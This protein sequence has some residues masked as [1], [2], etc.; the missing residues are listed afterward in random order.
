M[1]KFI[2]CPLLALLASL[3]AVSTRAWTLNPIYSTSQRRSI[4]LSKLAVIDKQKDMLD[5]MEE[6]MESTVGDQPSD[7]P[8]ERDELANL[9]RCI[10]RAAD[11]RKADNIVAIRISK[12][13]SLASFVVIL[14]GNSRPQNQAI[15][16]AIKSDV[17][18]DF[19]LL[20]G[21]TGV[22]EG[23]ADS[24]WM[25]LDYGSVMVHVMTPKSRLYYNVEGQ[26]SEKGEYMDL[27]D[28]LVPNAP[29]SVDKQSLDVPEEEDPFWS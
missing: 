24:G 25:V 18:D 3:F 5:F 26:W 1:S 9:V 23:T 8:P 13:S 27:S 10:A 29:V 21:S 2:I 16:A 11:G 20:P 6:P 15:A 4:S 14:S 7:V 22:P 12:F 17:A 28:I 19:D